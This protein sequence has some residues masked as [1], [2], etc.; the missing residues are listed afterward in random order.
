MDIKYVRFSR[1]PS[2]Q[3]QFLYVKFIVLQAIWKT[4]SISIKSAYC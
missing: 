2:I 4:P 3:L 1:K